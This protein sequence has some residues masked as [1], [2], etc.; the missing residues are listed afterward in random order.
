MV[1][2]IF[3]FA[4]FIGLFCLETSFIASLPKPLSYTPLILAS[5]IFLI[6]YR[7]SWIGICWLAGYG[8]LLDLFGLAMFKPQLLLYSLVGLA[9]WQL[10]KHL[11]TNRSLYGIL[12]SGLVA[13]I[14]VSFTEIAYLL[15]QAFFLEND[16]PQIEIANYYLF[17]LV[18]FILILFI[19]FQSSHAFQKQKNI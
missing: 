13:F 16:L 12:G 1:K 6:Q 17:K 14:M 4:L 18:L 7:S 2:F 8:L 9:T 3:Y 5:S 11:F 15:F 19:F 10:S